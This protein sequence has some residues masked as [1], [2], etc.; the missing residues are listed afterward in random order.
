[1]AVVLIFFEPMKDTAV[2]NTNQLSEEFTENTSEAID[3]ESTR[4]WLESCTF[5]TSAGIV[6]GTAAEIIPDS[7]RSEIEIDGVA[8][9]FVGLGAQA[10]VYGAGNKILKVGHSIHQ[11]FEVLEQMFPG[12]GNT[13]ARAMEN[14]Q[15]WNDIIVE[16]RAHLESGRVAPALIANTSIEES[17]LIWQ[18]KV[19]P[20][21]EYY[22]AEKITDYSTSEIKGLIDSFAESFI[23]SWR[24]GMADTECSLFSNYGFGQDTSLTMHDFGSATFSYSE[25]LQSVRGQVTKAEIDLFLDGADVPQSEDWPD[26]FSKGQVREALRASPELFTYYVETMSNTVNVTSLEKHWLQ[27]YQPSP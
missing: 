6:R 7:L 25:A 26:W 19:T 9:S 4:N 8:Y 3:V 23:S 20:V 17:G 16:M 22:N 21:E 2:Q 13:L 12:S 27:D 15:A 1:M 18:D 14:S 5:P 24:A 11:S 10:A